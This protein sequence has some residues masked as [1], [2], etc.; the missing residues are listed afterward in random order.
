MVNV[1]EVGKG[2]VEQTIEGSGTVK[3]LGGELEEKICFKLPNEDERILVKISKIQKTGK[4][5]PR[6]AGVP[7][8]EPLH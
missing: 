4:K 3:I 7:S 6:K 1:V 2:E 5:Y 8:R